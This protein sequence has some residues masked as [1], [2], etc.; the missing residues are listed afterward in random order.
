MLLRAVNIKA[1][2]NALELGSMI[3]ARRAREGQRGE[4]LD[5]VRLRN[6]NPELK[7]PYRLIT[8]TTL[9]VKTPY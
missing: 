1:L 8:I 9:K 5:Q 4:E 3:L 7:L 6:K 2:A